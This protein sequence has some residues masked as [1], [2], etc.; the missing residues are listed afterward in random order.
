[1]RIHTLGLPRERIVT[2]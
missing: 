2:C 1:M